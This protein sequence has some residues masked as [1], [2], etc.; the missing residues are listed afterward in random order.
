M[1]QKIVLHCRPQV[2]NR[3]YLEEMVK[4]LHDK[5]ETLHVTPSVNNNLNVK[6]TEADLTQ[7][8]DL[9]VVY[10]G[11]GSVLSIVRQLA[12]KSTP[13]LGVSGGTLG[14]FSE[15]NVQ[16]LEETL[17]QIER[18]EHVCDPRSL[19]Q[20]EV[21]DNN[22]TET[23]TALNE[24]TITHNDVARMVKLD[25]VIN[26]EYLTSYHADGLIIATPTGSTAY[27]LAAGG[28][29]VYPS[30]IPA[31]ILTPISPHSFSQRPL[32]IPDDKE[33]TITTNKDND[34]PTVLTA[35]GQQTI[36]LTQSSKITITVNDEKICLVRLPDSSFFKTIKRKLH[37]G[38][39]G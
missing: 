8:Y 35:D 15:I 29:I 32:L 20:I 14:F 18:G 10:G 24:I 30:K 23:I 4:I 21:N 16:N 22:K 36:N 33:I 5:S 37:W 39:S 9:C 13:I 2:S 26:G 25:A 27:S 38:L 7:D 12:N 6:I 3:Q 17:A 11:D 28:P 31:I 19:L 1:F 34:T